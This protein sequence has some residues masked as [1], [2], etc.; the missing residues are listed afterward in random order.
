[1]ADAAEPGHP[2]GVLSSPPR[3]RGLR[4]GRT[5]AR[6]RQQRRDVWLAATALLG[7]LLALPL[8]QSA[9]HGPEVAAVLVVSATALFAGQR[10]AIALIVIAE[11]FLL[12]TVW[13]RAF[14]SGDLVSRVM[15][16]VT[17][18]SIVP[19]VLAMR[20]AAAVIVVMTGQHRTQRTCRRVHLGLIAV[21]VIAVLVPF[22]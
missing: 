11:L 9:W 14:L 18:A 16:M 7:G 13:P 3:V 15:A 10:W 22:L 17:L 8:A 19:G 4:P 21:S 20:R 6:N 12:P 1:M 2:E 5:S